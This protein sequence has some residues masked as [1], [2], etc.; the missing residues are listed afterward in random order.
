MLKNALKKATKWGLVGLVS[1]C[2]FQSSQLN[3]MLERLSPE[4]RNDAQSVYWNLD[5][6]GLSGQLIPVVD[7]D[8][9]FFTDL[10]RWMVVFE[11][12]LIT[13]IYNLETG[14]KLSIAF[15]DPKSIV[16]NMDTPGELGKP[17]NI[18]D[19]IA[20][21]AYTAPG[22]PASEYD[23]LIHCNADWQVVVDSKHLTELT[24]CVPKG[25]TIKRIRD[26][27]GSLLTVTYQFEETTLIEITKTTEPVEMSALI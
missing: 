23:V 18:V 17:I 5:G 21:L 7:A 14:S 1:G 22:R 16:V 11:R 19:A 15:I 26:I 9:I 3:F 12:D 6:Q 10:I 2:S 13:G 8:R 4:S 20:G 27:E 25:L 24:D